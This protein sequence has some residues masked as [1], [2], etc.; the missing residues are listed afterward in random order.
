MITLTLLLM[1]L[2]KHN[3]NVPEQKSRKEM[4]ANDIEERK[5]VQ[6]YSRGN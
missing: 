2:Y 6:E 5:R 4:E 1:N 3:S